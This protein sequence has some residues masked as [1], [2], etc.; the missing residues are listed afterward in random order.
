MAKKK[1]TAPSMEILVEIGG[2]AVVSA[3][4]KPSTD[5]DRLLEQQGAESFVFIPLAKLGK[6]KRRNARK[7]A[8]MKMKL[9]PGTWYDGE[10]RSTDDS[11]AVPGVLAFDIRRRNAREIAESLGVKLF[12]WGTSGVPFEQH[13]VQIFED[14]DS[15][16][17]KAMRRRALDGLSDMVASAGNIGELPTAVLESQTTMQK[18]WQLVAIVLGVAVAAG[19]VQAIIFWLLGSEESASWMVTNIL[20]YP[21]VIP[22]VFVGI[23]LRVLVRKGE[24]DARDFTAGEA[25]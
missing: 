1:K 11:D 4:G 6:R 5:L 23:Y 17:W 10:L 13:A 15:R 21:I 7:L 19:I 18:F 3:P 12:F 25:E 22:A 2:L 14:I 9:P 24:E 20:F 8:Q 16:E